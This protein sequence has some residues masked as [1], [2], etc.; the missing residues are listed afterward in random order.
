MKKIVLLLLI[1]FCCYFTYAQTAKTKVIKGVIIDSLKKQP[2]SYVTVTLQDAASG[3]QIRSSLTKENGTFEINGTAGI[4]YKLAVT[5]IGFKNKV[6]AI[7]ADQTDLGKVLL[8]ESGKQLNEVAI[9]AAKPI[10][11]QEVD[12]ISYDVQTDPESKVL[13]VL[14][15]LRK[16]PMVSVDATD[17][18]KLKGTG[19]YKI[20]INGKESALI[21]KNPSDVF[22]AMPAS[23]IERIE[24]ITTPPAKYDAEGLAGI[25]NIITKKNADQGYNGSVNT[26]YNSV[27]G[28]G[29]N[30]NATVKQGKIGLSG[31][32]GY[33]KQ[34]KQTTAFGNSNQIIKPVI[35]NQTQVGDNSRRGN[36]L[37]GSAE[38]SFEIDTLNLITGSYQHYNGDNTTANNQYATELNAANVVT[39]SY[40]LNNNGTS[41]YNGTDVGINYQL[42][43]KRNKDQLLTTSYKY[44]VGGNSQN[45]GA[46]YNLYT[47]TIGLNTQPANYQQNNNSGNK[48][49]TIQLDYVHP[50]KVLTIEAGAKGILR[51]SYS[52]FENY[53]QNSSGA[54]LIDPSQTNAFDYSQ[55]VYSI[56]NSYQLKLKKWV[57][58]GGLRMEFTDV[59]ANF[60]TASSPAKSDYSNLIPSVSMQRIINDK[61]NITLGFT[62]RIQ[63]P[64]IWQLNPFVDKTN[65]KFINTG[66][67]NLQPV[68]NHT[69]ELNYSNFAKGSLT[70][71]VNYAFANNT[72]QNVFKVGPD[73]ITTS[74]YQN[75]GKNKRLGLDVNTN[76]PI[77][78]S[79][80]ININAEL[81]HVWLNGTYNG[82]FYDAKGFQGHIFTYT[83]YKSD[84]GY[85][86]GLNIGYDSRYVLL[87]GRD[88]EFLFSSVSAQKDILKKK[89]TI[90]LSVNNPFEKFKKLDYYSSSDSFSQI[91]YN[92]IYARTINV[93]F[94]YK[95]GK[96]NS[97]L[98]KNQRGISNDDVN[99]GGRN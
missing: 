33:S 8:P 56:Y 28:P 27:Y 13:T 2:M 90:S 15:M 65:P 9:T 42:G 75:I 25:I 74:T 82:E 31:Y 97:Q 35:T 67:P 66:N 55:D 30:L 37:Y 41:T 72:V 1:N 61:N 95:F 57:G 4:A 29:V 63:R 59:S 94:N 19:D 38:L 85:N 77:T 26:R 58:K 46:V 68:T 39:Q 89:A 10:V 52:N 69:V 80:N 83:S 40:Y 24:V 21:A 87:Q 99:G 73:T 11:R 18:I 45:V 81:L 98:K 86:I 36:N 50:L 84:K 48:E 49:H 47:S 6:V 71:G 91:N 64:G 43:F 5:F 54:Y 88:N 32:V 34:Q 76:Y 22:K 70:V 20:L 51:S 44:S 23:N 62:E 79:I 92:N 17:N 78:K 60:N 96:L 7:A 3:A 12:R 53:K 16:V 93:S 14:D